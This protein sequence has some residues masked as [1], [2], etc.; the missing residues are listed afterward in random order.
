MEG[1][2]AEKR[3]ETADPLSPLIGLEIEDARAWAIQFGF[4]IRVISR[5]G[6]L[7][8]GAGYPVPQRILLDMSEGVVIK[9]CFG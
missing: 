2:A 3:D 4:H 6:R 7:L 9:A 8:H 5:D 1:N